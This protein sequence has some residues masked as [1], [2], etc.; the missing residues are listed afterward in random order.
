MRRVAVA[1]ITCAFVAIAFAPAAAQATFPGRNGA[2]IAT[3][4][5]HGRPYVRAIDPST[6]AVRTV[7]KCV[8]GDCPDFIVG[9]GVSA[10]GTR[11]AFDGT[12]FIDRGDSV[13]R[14]SILRIATEAVRQLPLLAGG[15]D[16]EE[17][18]DPSWFPGTGRLLFDVRTPNAPTG[19]FSAAAD[20]S[21]VT[22]LLA[23]D[24]LDAVASPNGQQILFGRGQ[25]LWIARSDGSGARRLQRNAEEPSWSPLG[26]RIAFVSNARGRRD[27]IVERTNGRGRVTLAHNVTSPVFSPNGKLLAFDRCTNCLANDD[28]SNVYTIRQNGTGLRLLFSDHPGTDIGFG[29]LDWQALPR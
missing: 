20:G 29:Q 23:C 21:S 10:D 7:F 5:D 22:K 16:Q 17:D 11:A 6:G 26:R 9:L 2:I 8:R 19:L 15:L 25:D 13:T 18:Q 27:L 1:V 28:S 24:C 14:I 12:T 3:F 4:D